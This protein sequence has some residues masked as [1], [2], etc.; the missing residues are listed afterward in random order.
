M[1]ILKSR[2]L[3]TTFRMRSLRTETFGADEYI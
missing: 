1:M 2:D 3:R